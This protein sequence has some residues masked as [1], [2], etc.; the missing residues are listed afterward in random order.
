MGALF[1]QEQACLT[2]KMLFSISSD[3]NWYTVILL[4][5]PQL[6][7]FENLVSK[8]DLNQSAHSNTIEVFSMYFSKYCLVDGFAS[9][10]L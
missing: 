2:T 6:T 5:L 8:D 4:T 3:Q 9:L 10:E 1:I 7:G